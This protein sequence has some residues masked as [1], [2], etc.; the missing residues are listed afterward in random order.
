MTLSLQY[1]SRIPAGFPGRFPKQG[2]TSQR[3]FPPATRKN[4]GHPRFRATGVKVSR[5]GG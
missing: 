5:S 4:V 2:G 3:L 1:T